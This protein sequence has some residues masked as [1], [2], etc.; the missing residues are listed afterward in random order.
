MFFSLDKEVHRVFQKDKSLSYEKGT[1]KIADVFMCALMIPL[2][3][4][5]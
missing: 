3:V 4:L 1:E 5:K 2:M